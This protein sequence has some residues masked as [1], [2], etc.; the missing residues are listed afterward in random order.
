MAITRVMVTFFKEFNNHFTLAESSDVIAAEGQGGF[1]CEES[2][3]RMNEEAQTND[4]SAA[5]ITASR[6]DNQTRLPP[7]RPRK[8]TI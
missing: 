8:P 5:A 4:H 2:S 1:E 7:K 3:G 6:K